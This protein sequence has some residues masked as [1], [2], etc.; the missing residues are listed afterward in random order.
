MVDTLFAAEESGFNGGDI[1]TEIISSHLL[2]VSHTPLIAT[3]ELLRVKII[4][5]LCILVYVYLRVKCLASA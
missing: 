2:T 5:P 1:L 4:V 3:P